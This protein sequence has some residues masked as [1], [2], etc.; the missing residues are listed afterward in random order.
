MKLTGLLHS[1]DTIISPM[2]YARATFTTRPDSVTRH[3]ENTIRFYYKDYQGDI[4]DLTVGDL[5]NIT[6]DDGAF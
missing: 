6:L 4:N 3:N 2:A 1:P 5:R